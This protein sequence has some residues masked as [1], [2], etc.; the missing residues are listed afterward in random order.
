VIKDPPFGQKLHNLDSG[1]KWDELKP[2]PKHRQDCFTYFSLMQ[3][4][5]AC[6]WLEYCPAQQ[7]H[8]VAAALELDGWKDAHEMYFWKSDQNMTGMYQYIWSVD[9]AMIA[10]KPTMNKVPWVGEPN[11][12]TRQNLVVSRGMMKKRLTDVQGNPVNKTEKNPMNAR[13]ICNRHTKPGDNVLVL[14]TGAG[15]DVEG[16]LVSGCSVVGVESDKLQFDACNH[17]IRE[18][19]A[20]LDFKIRLLSG[21]D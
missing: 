3:Q 20:A 18:L 5:P 12:L 11:P 10:Y 21:A 17:R 7:T 15:G 4:A 8:E 9:P 2:T 19:L 13:V 14:G 6:V 1:K 16:A